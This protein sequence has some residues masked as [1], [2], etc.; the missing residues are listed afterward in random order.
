[1]N[2]LLYLLNMLTGRFWFRWRRLTPG[3]YVVTYHRIG[4]KGRTDF[5]PNVFSCTSKTFEQHLCFYKKYF[6]VVTPRQLNGEVASFK[7]PV[8]CI[9]FDDGYLDNFEIALPLLQKHGLN[10][11][12]FVT[13]NYVKQVKIPWW[14][15]IAWMLQNSDTKSFNLAWTG[16]RQF[17]VAQ[18]RSNNHNLHKFM[19]VIKSHSELSMQKKLVLLQN[20]LAITFDI[21]GLTKPLFM[22]ESNVTE[23]KN[24]GM[25]IGGHTMNH[26]ILSH[27]SASEQSIEINQNKQ[28]LEGLTK[29]PVTT[30]AYPVGSYDCYDQDTLDILKKSG[31][32]IAFTYEN[33]LNLKYNDRPFE[34]LRFPIEMNDS[35]H[36]LKYM[37]S[38][39][40]SLNN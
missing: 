36:R 33:G 25:E 14:D 22:S 6:D 3:L 26:P 24:A 32:K 37:M 2:K 16:E 1:M 29:Q 21:A 38:F 39:P 40:R 18:I 27:L 7:K 15:E 35:I 12:F 10:A 28:H 30:F 11:T 17:D 8:L 31:Y 20:I 34:L 5:D 19:T 23:M 4:D 13:S 9:T